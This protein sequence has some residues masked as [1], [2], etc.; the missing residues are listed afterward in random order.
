M[1]R[2]LVLAFTFALIFVL[3]P[4]SQAETIFEGYYKVIRSGEH[5][6]FYIMKHEFDPKKKHFIATTFMKM[7]GDKS[8]ETESIKAIADENFHP[9]NYSYTAIAGGN[10]KTIDAKFE[11]G[12]IV[13]SATTNGKA[14]KIIKPV[15]KNAFL[16]AFLIYTILR[17]PSGMKPKSSFDY[18]AIAEETGEASKGVAELKDYEMVEGLKVLKVKNTF[19]D[20]SSDN[21][22]S[23]KGEILATTMPAAKM[24][25]E[26]VAQPSNAT[27]DMKVPSSI[28]T[29]LFGEVPTGQR[30]MFADLHHSSGD[31]DKPVGKLGG[32][33]SGPKAE[34]EPGAT[35]QHG[36][37]PGKGI[38]L[39]VNDGKSTTGSAPETK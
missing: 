16:S 10:T 2:S 30:N 12:K 29:Q 8:D 36:V 6:G 1:V 38:Q 9:L 5:V 25:L 4:L 14:E 20:M 34:I 7:K 24:S 31:T 28:L 26:L 13:A 21:M 32:V 22:V 39:K 33:K 19:L 27:A 17:S 23:E 35:K 15:D 3:S 37:P 11:K 18:V